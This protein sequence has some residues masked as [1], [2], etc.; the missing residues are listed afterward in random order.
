MGGW[1]LGFRVGGYVSRLYG[2]TENEIKKE[3]GN[4]RGTEII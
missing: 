2:I 4:D 3:H 1:G